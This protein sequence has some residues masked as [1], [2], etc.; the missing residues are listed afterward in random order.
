MSKPMSIPILSDDEVVIKKNLHHYQD[1]IQ[2]FASTFYNL[3]NT[4]LVKGDDEP[5]YRPN[6]EQCD[7]NQI[8]FAHGYYA[9]ALHEVSHWCLAGASRRLLE[10]F[11]YWYIP[12]GRDQNQQQAFEQVEIKPQAIEWALCVATGKAFDVSSDNLLGKGETD[13]VAFKA[14]VYQQVLAYLEYGFP[15]DA[16]TFIIAL[17]SYYQTPWPLVSEHFKFLDHECF[18]S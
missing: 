1:L 13:R 12:D 14:K 15:S 6:N 18:S 17:T 16:A 4:R 5:I 9:S 11:G 2:L 7:F 3:Y 8:V 10:D